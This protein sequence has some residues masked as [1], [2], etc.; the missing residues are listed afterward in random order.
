MKP[1]VVAVAIVVVGVTGARAGIDQPIYVIDSPTAGLLDHGE[2]HAQGRLGPESSF[3]LAFRIG[4]K[5]VVHAGL[6]FGMQRVFERGSVTVNDKV[7]VLL[8]IRILQ[9]GR[10]PAFALG[11][12]SQGTGPYDE[13]RERYER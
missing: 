7:G 12:N 9:E 2:L 6:A 10:G 11:F 8:R 4:F 3:L 1:V 5:G 13:A